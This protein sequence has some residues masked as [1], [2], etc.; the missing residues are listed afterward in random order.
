MK[1]S[2]SFIQK[3]GENEPYQVR[4][5]IQEKAEHYDLF[6]LNLMRIV[7]LENPVSRPRGLIF[8]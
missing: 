1:S 2:K 3:K 5:P 7:V 6:A 8:F 4:E